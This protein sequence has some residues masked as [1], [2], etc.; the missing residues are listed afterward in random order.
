M[1]RLL[2][3][4]Y[5]VNRIL[6]LTEKREVEKSKIE[7]ASVAGEEEADAIIR[8]PTHYAW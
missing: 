8:L 7:M 3:S 4:P 2:I 1:D 5:S 6:N